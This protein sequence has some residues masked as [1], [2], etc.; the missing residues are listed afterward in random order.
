M[1][2]KQRR[3]KNGRPDKKVLAEIVQSIVEAVQPDKNIL[4]GSAARCEMGPNSDI[5]LLV[6]KSGKFSHDRV[7]R[8]IYRPRP[9]AAAVDALVVT[10]DDLE[11]YG[12]S[13]YLVY[14]P[15][16]HE[17]KV[18]YDSGT[19][20]DHTL[21]GRAGERSRALDWLVR[22]PNTQKQAQI[23]SGNT[24][25]RKRYPPTDPR[26]W[27]NRAKS[28]LEGAA[29]A[30]P[31]VYLEDLCFDAQQA[32]EKAI[33]AVFI[34]RGETFPYIHDLDRLL[35]LLEIN[36]LKIPLYVKASKELTRF[37]LEP[38]YPGSSGPI[39]RRQYRRALRIAESV[40]RC[41]WGQI[42]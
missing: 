34:H 19:I 42:R 31:G 18:I 9:G 37:A 23:R 21:T 38:R 39:N 35:E 30:A 2:S 11:R 15:A 41:Q 14:Y 20:R 12:D 24:M 7:T 33:K 6:V 10:P 13:P 3:R 32:A 1:T 26:E 22:R 5:D 27:L 4:F 16:V 28:N 36:G 25:G 40:V 29:H 8:D 17:G